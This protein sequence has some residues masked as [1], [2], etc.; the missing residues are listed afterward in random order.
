MFG[1]IP[2]P[3][4]RVQFTDS[5]IFSQSYYTTC[6]RRLLM[7]FSERNCGNPCISECRLPS[8]PFETY[9]IR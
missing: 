5:G 9:Y 6:S 1:R 4:S 7:F 2:P 8:A 3:Q